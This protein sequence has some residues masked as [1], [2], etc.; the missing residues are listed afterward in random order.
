MPRKT[1]KTTSQE[2]LQVPCSN[3]QQENDHMAQDEAISA[4][5]HRSSHTIAL[6]DQRAITNSSL[7]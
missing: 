5:H 4:G 6:F 7:V 3:F 1:L 2:K